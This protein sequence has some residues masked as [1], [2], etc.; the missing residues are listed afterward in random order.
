MLSYRTLTNGPVHYT[1]GVALFTVM[2]HIHFFEFLQSWLEV[3]F[4]SIN[5]PGHFSKISIIQKILKISKI[6][7]G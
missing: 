6:I 2:V 1:K 4:I 7:E 5:E 3:M